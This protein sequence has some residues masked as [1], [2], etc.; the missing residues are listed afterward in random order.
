MKSLTK[1]NPLK[2]I[3]YFSIPIF[4]GRLLQL[5]YSIVDTRIVGTTLGE[6]A[7]AAVGGTST[8]SDLMVDLMMGVTGGFSIVIA[9]AFGAKDEDR[10]KKGVA[11]AFGL[12][13]VISLML[14]VFSLAF[15][16]GILGLLNVPAEIYADARGY[17]SVILAGFICS[18]LYNACAAVLRAIGD[19][20]TPLL[21]LIISTLLNIA[22]DYAFILGLGM[23]VSGAALATVISQ[24]VSFV[25]CFVYMW[26]KYPILHFKVSNSF[27][28]HEL[29]SWMMKTGGSMGFMA[30]FVSLGTVCLQTAINTFGTDIIVAHAAARKITMIFMLPF[31]VFGQ[32][33]ATYCGQ[34]M[35]AWEYLRIKEGIK[36]TVLLTWGWCLLVIVLANTVAASLVTMITGSTNPVILK[37]AVLYLR[38][39][40]AFY[41]VPTMIA[42]IRNSL[43]G[44]GDA[45]T[46][47]ISSFIELFGKVVIALFLAPVIG[48]MGIIVAEPI[49]WTLMVIPLLISLTRAF[50][51]WEKGA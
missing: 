36:Q 42:L 5:F 7:L 1:G 26:R 19:S 24:A 6:A 43:Q 34:N 27:E 10:M 11:K 39:D 38:V 20:L 47:V 22:L 8:L 3:L 9:T 37:N 44:I 21:F 48:Y 30:A 28:D 51:L 13:V 29:T 32:A 50:S 35:G 45:K 4:I 18:S 15:L 31:G 49:V 2:L 25:L 46:P 40:T 16:D 33:L 41:F 17:I 14:S 23:G 12:T